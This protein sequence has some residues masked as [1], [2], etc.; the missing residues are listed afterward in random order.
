MVKIKR[1]DHIQI[2]IP[3]GMEEQARGF[4][5]NIMGW[6]EIQKP[7]ALIKNGGL[8]YEL[9]DIQFHIGCEENIAPSKRHPAFEVENIES[10]KTYFESMNVK[11]KED[12]AIPGCLRFSIIDPFDNRIEFLEKINE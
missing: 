6:N 1:L 9:G 3:F 10:L 7:E 8:W 4:Y 2:C 5:T 12:I 11:M